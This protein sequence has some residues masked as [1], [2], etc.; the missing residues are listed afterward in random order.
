MRSDRHAA[1]TAPGRTALLV[2]QEPFL[3]K[4][5]DKLGSARPERGHPV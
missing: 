1:L 2:S 3:L 4:L 5:A